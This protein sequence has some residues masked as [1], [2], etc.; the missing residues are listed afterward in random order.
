[1]QPAST[2]DPV[3]AAISRASFG[4]IDPVTKESL[5][6]KDILDFGTLQEVRAFHD[7]LEAALEADDANECLRVHHHYRHIF[8]ERRRRGDRQH[9]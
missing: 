6:M 3:L 7:A 2:D 5:Q 8:L 9:S 4:I 1:M